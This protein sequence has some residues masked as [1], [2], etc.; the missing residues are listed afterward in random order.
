MIANRIK[1]IHDF[2]VKHDLAM[3]L[4]TMVVM[5]LVL[6]I[7]DI[8]CPTRFLSGI[9][10]PGCGMTRAVISLLHLDINGAVHYHPLV[11]TLPIIAFLFINQKRIN[12]YVL[13]TILALI[14]VAFVVVYLVRLIDP[15]NEVV[16][17]DIRRGIIYKIFYKLTGGKYVL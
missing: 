2:I 7:V 6:F 5:A 10:C 3:S 11:F 9:C 4:F 16:Y 8:G 17:A 1:K 13:N 14:I 15:S 12:T